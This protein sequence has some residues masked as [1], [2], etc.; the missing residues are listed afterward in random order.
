M[1][2]ITLAFLLV[3]SVTVAFSQDNFQK[4]YI[5]NLSGDTVPG[6][7]DY[8]EWAGSPEK[9]LFKN[10]DGTMVSYTNKQISYF[11]IEGKVAYRSYGGY[12]TNDPDKTS[13]IGGIDTSKILVNVFV[14]YLRK[15]KLVSL[16]HYNDKKKERFF[17]EDMALHQISE[18]VQHL[19]YTDNSLRVIS[20]K[21]YKKQLFD[22][23][24][25]KHINTLEQKIENTNYKE[26]ELLYIIGMINNTEAD[27]VVINKKAS[28]VKFFAGAAIN[29]AS[30]KYTGDNILSSNVVREGSFYPKITAGIDLYANPDIGR[31]V[32]R[33]EISL[34]QSQ[35]KFRTA[36]GEGPIN[37]YTQLTTTLSPQ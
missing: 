25:S 31:V 5:V 18:L 32:F 8:R 6:A 30:A 27:E 7:I 23:A 35:F 17:V 21:R 12:I 15:G 28:S 9:I 37:N 11:E 14:E 29:I 16:L 2:K 19:Y 13:D 36:V 20:L 3:F 1:L 33:T 4:G 10:V 24:V 22:M 34:T 26:N